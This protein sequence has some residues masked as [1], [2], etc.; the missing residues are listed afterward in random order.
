MRRALP[1]LAILL[2]PVAAHA[3]VDTEMDRPYELNVVLRCGAHNWLGKQFRTDLRSNLAGML[4]DALGPM[5]DIKVID[6]KELPA[7]Q[8]QPLWK[9]VDTRGLDVLDSPREGGSGKTHFLRVDFVNGHYE[10]HGRQLDGQTGLVS[11]WRK[12]R[13]PDRAFVA[14]LA[15]RMIA[16]DFGLTGTIVG[17]GE[18]VQVQFRGGNLTNRLDRWVHPGDV[19]ALYRVAPAAR[20]GAEGAKERVFRELD[21]IVRI[22]GEPKNG[23]CTAKIVH[24][25]AENPVEKAPASISFRC[26]RLSA[27]RGPMRLRLVNELGQPHNRTLQVRVHTEGFQ[28]EEAVDEEII[29]SDRGGLFISKRSYDQL[30]YARIVT[31]ARQIARVPVPIQENNEVV[32]TV[33]LDAEGEEAGRLQALRADLVRQFNDSIVVQINSYKDVSALV[34]EAKNEAALKR[35]K[36]A[37]AALEQDQER[38]G[39]RKEY[40]QKEL[41]GSDISL[42]ECEKAEQMLE[43]HRT[44]I[45]R[46]IG[47]LEE[48]IRLENAPDRVEK[49]NRLQQ[50]LT[51]AVAAYEGDDY[52]TAI[53]IYRQIV[54]EYPEEAA[55]KKRLEQLD[56][57]WSIKS[58]AHGNARLYVTRDWPGSKNAAE[59]AGKLDQLKQAIQVLV[60]NRDKLTLLK[61]RNS[62]P[63]VTKVLRDEITALAQSGSEDAE[64][65]A[66][67]TKTI[68][69]FDK[70]Q[71]EVDG[72][73]RTGNK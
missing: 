36:A 61:L 72:L 33:R 31:G 12:E 45:N 6:L 47:Q 55:I 16:N 21:T 27:N 1:L 14:R 42:A 70:I 53:E 7:D 29:N 24:R 46:M 34:R 26:I 19:F 9:E 11:P 50:M 10:I 57:D 23:A 37:R 32:V 28:T 15:G 71:Q 62:F 43:A 40:V 65:K 41:A 8:W 68:T 56:A 63:E 35:A 13:T 3:Q 54:K 51:K 39:V 69:D 25:A 49:R 59:V 44:R 73:L 52:D 17:K 60:Q 2:L 18:E 30:A 4:S 64:A 66:K 5:A 38:L 20:N 22:T 67:L 48:T 58:D